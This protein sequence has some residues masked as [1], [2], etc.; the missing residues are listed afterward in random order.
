LIQTNPNRRTAFGLVVAKA[1]LWRVGG[2][3]AIYTNVWEPNY[4]PEA[5]RYR[6]IYTN[7][8]REPQPVDWMHERE[9]RVRGGLSLNQPDLPA[10][11]WWPMVPSFADLTRLYQTTGAN[12][13]VYV[14]EAGNVYWMQPPTGLQGT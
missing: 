7:L 1:A 3:P 6:V 8:E 4:W 12:Y 2:R 13:Q 11:W 14:L 5:E 9:W 10:V